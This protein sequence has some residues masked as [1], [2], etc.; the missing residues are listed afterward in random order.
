MKIIIILILLFLVFIAC[1]KKKEVI[2]KVEVDVIDLDKEFINAIEDGDLV[3][4]ERLIEAGADVNVQTDDVQ[5]RTALY[6]AAGY[7]YIEIITLLLE[8]RVDIN[9][10]DN[11]GRTALMYA[12]LYGNSQSVELL[13]NAGVDI[14]IQNNNNE[15]ALMFAVV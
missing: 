2:A 7:N 1:D 5:G 11:W 14:N 13:V 3:G 9:Y 12:A 8:A 10:Q 6:I 15:T 4:V